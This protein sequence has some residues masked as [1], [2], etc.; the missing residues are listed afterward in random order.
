MK[1]FKTCR[2]LSLYD[3]LNTVSASFT[4]GFL[5]VNGFKNA[6]GLLSKRQLIRSNRIQFFLKKAALKV[7]LTVGLEVQMLFHNS[8]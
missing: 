6:G 4:I 1:S 5:N 8:P 2:N 7:L 3:F